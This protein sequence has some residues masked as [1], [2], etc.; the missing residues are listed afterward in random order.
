VPGW[1]QTLKS[2]SVELR[3]QKSLTVS[4]NRPPTPILPVCMPWGRHLV[5]QN[6]MAGRTPAPLYGPAI[7]KWQ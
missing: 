2:R 5:C 6:H 7:N 3:A 4:W 1:L